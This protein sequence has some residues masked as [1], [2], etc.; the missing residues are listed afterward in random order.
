M[1]G[2]L[3]SIIIPAFNAG[4]NIRL[5][6]DSVLQQS[7]SNLEIIVVDDGSTD[8]T[9][10]VI[11]S[12]TDKRVRYLEQQNGGQCKA[13]NTGLSNAAG[14]LIRFFDA[15]DVLNKE[16]IELQVKKINNRTDAICSCEWGRFYDSNPASA[17][18]HPETV[19]EDMKPIDWLKKALLQKS[20]MMGGWLWLIP[21]TIMD[22]TGGWDERLSLN[23]DFEFTIRLLLNA[24]EVLFTPGAKLYYRTGEE[25]LSVTKSKS[26]YEAAYLSTQL[27]CSYLLAAENSRQM[28]QLCANRYQEW[29]YQ[30]YPRYP[31]IYKKME[32]DIRDL[33]GSTVKVGGGKVL[34]FLALLFGWKTA[35]KIQ[36]SFYK[37]GYNK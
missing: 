25:T 1:T 6:I 30:F 11:K 13:S 33:G 7:Y 27:G 28:Q 20:D 34:K 16:H 12:Y 37:L 9:A 17:L 8:N 23:N 21:R 36:Y 22:K 19:W 10:S 4:K 3:V 32:R 15:D 24:N 31:A 2:P 18:F 29:I 5:S 35:K 14:D 26:A